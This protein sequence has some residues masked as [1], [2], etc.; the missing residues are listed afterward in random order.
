MGEINE[1]S[2]SVSKVIKVID[3][4]AFQTNL[5]ALN[6]AV[7]AARAGKFGKGFAVVAEEVRNLASRSAEAAKNTT[8]MIESSINQVESGVKNADQADEIL[9]EF[10]S[11]IE[12]VNDLVCEISAA[13]KEQS[14]GVGEISESLNLVNDVVQNNSSISEQTA[15]ASEQLKDQAET[16]QHLI[17]SF[18][19]NRDVLYQADPQSEIVQKWTAHPSQFE[20]RH[21][22]QSGLMSETC[23]EGQLQ[24]EPKPQKTG[25]LSGSDFK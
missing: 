7:E 11:I 13:S 21:Q 9:K 1:S 3:E 4:I 25:W 2:N 15:A 20:L 23:M 17:D 24:S 8:S 5:L 22:L 12:K 19:L 14:N 10:I 18:N 16:M 6:A